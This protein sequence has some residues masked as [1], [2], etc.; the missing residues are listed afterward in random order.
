MNLTSVLIILL[1][2]LVFGIIVWFNHR[3]T[4][5]ETKKFTSNLNN[6]VINRLLND[7]SL[8]FKEITNL[9][10]DLKDCKSA[11]NKQKVKIQLILERK[12]VSKRR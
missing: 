1:C 12:K 4:T 6:Q 10:S 11:I 8:Y 5:I 9:K 3:L 7:N 2:F